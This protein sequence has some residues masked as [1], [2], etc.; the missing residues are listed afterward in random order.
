M[1]NTQI[2]HLFL[3]GM[4]SGKNNNVESTNSFHKG[5]NGRLYSKNGTIAYSSIQGTKLVYTNP[6]IVAYLGFWAFEDELILFLKCKSEIVVGEG[7]IDYI[8][9]NK[10]QASSFGVTIPLLDDDI[11]IDLDPHVSE[12]ELIIPVFVPSEDALNFNANVSCVDAVPD[13][14]DLTDYYTENLDVEN[15]IPCPVG[16]NN[17]NYEN[18]VDFIDCIISLKKDSNG[19]IYDKLLWAGF[20]NWPM[21]GKIKAW[22]IFENN[23]YK[24]VYYTEYTNSF[25]V[26]NIMD[27]N[28]SQRNVS[29]LDTIQNA[30]MLQPRVVSITEDGSIRSGTVFYS[31]RLIT[32]NGQF[33]EFSP[34]SFPIKIVKEGTGNDYA[35][36]D[37]AEITNKKVTIQC[38]VLSFQNYNEIEA[39]AIEYQA[40]GAPTSI[41]SL[42]VKPINSIVVFDHTGN[43]PEFQNTITIS[44]LTERKNSFRY[45]S[46][47]VA[48]RNK[49]IVAGLRND[50]LPTE[51]LNIT[52]DF[53]LHSWDIDGETHNCLINPAPWQY[54]YIDPNNTDELF[55]IDKKLY[56]SIQVFQS[57]TIKIA[58]TQ[59]SE[60]I[61][62]SFVNNSQTYLNFNDAI[63]AWLDTI[64]ETVEFTT[65]F[66]NL[67]FEY[68]QNKIVF[69]P[70]DDLIQTDMNIY[71]FQY[72]TAQVVEDIEK[73]I[74][75]NPITVSTSSLIYGAV[76]LGFNKGNG[77][78]ITYQTELE[79][80]LTKATAVY[81]GSS[82]LL[83]LKEPNYAKT[84]VKGEI[85]RLSL[86]TFMD[87]NQSF[88]IPLGD[89]FIPE[90]GEFKKGLDDSGT[91]FYSMDYYQNS[92]VVGNK[93]YAEKVKLR[94]E[95]RLSCNIQK[96][97]SMY[98]LLY[99]ERDQANRTILTQGISAPLERCQ[100]F[101][102]SE[103][104]QM[105][106]E[107]EQKWN[108]PYNGG[109]TYD[110]N[111]LT[112]YDSNPELEDS[113]YENSTTRIVTNRKLFYFDSPEVTQNQI[114]E[115][116]L[117]I[118]QVQRVGRLNTD[119]TPTAIRQSSGEV[120]PKFSRKVYANEIDFSD[121]Y[122][123]YWIN[124]S[125]FAN[126]RSAD[127]QLFPVKN[128]AIL[129]DG[130]IIPG[131]DFDTNFEI[132]NNAL[133]LAR[134]SWFYSNYAR[135]SEKCGS[136]DGAK[137][138]LFNSSNF[139]IGRNTVVIATE[140]DFFTND[141]IS[142]VGFVPD[143]EVRL[144]GGIR[145]YDTHALVNIYRNNR[146]S[147]YGGRSELAY[148]QN[149]FTALSETI[150]VLKTSNGSQ[151]FKVYGDCYMTLYIR[152][153]NY[154]SDNERGF[155][156]MNN[157]GGCENKHEEEDYT[158]TGA[159]CYAVV[160][161]SMIEP[162]L[163]S[164]NLFW[165]QNIASNFGLLSEKINEGYFQ[166]SS[167]KSYI[168]KPFRF[169]DDPNMGNILAVSDEKLRG[170]F[171]DSWSN[172]RINNFYEL[173]KDKGTIFNLG[174]YLDQVFAI[175]ETKTAKLL[176]DPR[177][178]I[179]TSNGEI[180]VA[181]GSG[182]PVQ[183]HDY[184]SDFGTSIR[185][186]VAPILS[187]QA[188]IVGFSFY[189]EKRNEF[190][191]VTKGLLLENELHHEI[192]DLFK[193]NPVIDSEGYYD[194]EFKE[195]VIRLRTKNGSFYTLSY[196]E[197]L[198][199]FNGF[200]EYNNDLYITWNHQVFA[201]IKEIVLGDPSS[202]KLHQ[203]NRG[204][205]LNLF[206][207]DKKIVVGIMINKEFTSV[208]ILKHWAGVINVDYPFH[209]MYIKTSLGQER[210]IFGSHYKYNI[211]EGLHTVPTKN[212]TD[213]DDLRGSWFYLEVEF[214]SEKNNKIDIL[215]FIN[216]V[217]NSYL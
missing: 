116:Y 210:T 118:G 30:S 103:N 75:F 151:M 121:N 122:K 209:K 173:D 189:D 71:Q 195:T 205:Y 147:V 69:L 12:I 117:K 160:L 165:R 206:E 126:E 181:Q 154:F 107:V 163:S 31:Y 25:R 134:Q 14:I 139:S 188:D 2:L 101:F 120:Y 187:S 138:E 97:V 186:A 140:N 53:A 48:N 106:D 185:R 172:F 179:P 111:G 161:E 211:K 180:S 198:K 83:N 88:A 102:H 130:E 26:I 200:F 74:V 80:I 35:G 159:W 182:T 175:Q 166:E 22:G 38:N 51:L 10:L 100:N 66:P 135:K 78:K 67:K 105:P 8:T 92:R 3:E 91:P 87:R 68:T 85:Y 89:I 202:S 193:E 190:V 82:P 5:V 49:L 46:D 64:Q 32:A 59:T 6:N 20:Q 213:W 136:E 155:K 110:G 184:L 39:V 86:Q 150:P 108:L 79:E 104:I 65:K 158:R 61:E 132:S 196:N 176:I 17:E 203:L 152:N 215:S 153:K 216:F 96:L 29:E 212:R 113:G 84:F 41:R 52:E 33:T 145:T 174:Y 60:F 123:P 157:S 62:E 114:I 99:V 28:L 63:F 169:K 192:Y 72:N 93:L 199:C 124:I 146:E 15:L 162:K 57:F 47:L 131:T 16:F 109:P 148:S 45:V 137:S 1:K 81:P 119:H 164:E 156:D 23:F 207:Q 56:N 127:K 115:D 11:V 55:Y 50:P 18:N 133:T 13:E 98:Q 34:F 171:Y 178:M 76:S 194:D 144:S 54:R 197:L 191:R 43:E 24:R 214:L 167:L 143:G 70:V 112:Q 37:I 177:T 217:R 4:K 168:P 90:H 125:V 7:T 208:K 40:K 42:G 128:A 9:V 204:I 58:N 142:Q 73:N 77:I 141:F 183:D 27:Q 44:D 149:V 36:G 170:N 201:P 95:V 21:N 19:N 129:N 94:V